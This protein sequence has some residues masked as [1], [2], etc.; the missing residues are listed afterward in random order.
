V[1]EGKGKK[2]VSLFKRMGGLVVIQEI[3]KRVFKNIQ[4]N[5]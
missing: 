4:V 2:E 1:K 5:N 3:T